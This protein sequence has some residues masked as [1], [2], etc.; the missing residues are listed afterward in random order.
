[1]G[2]PAK[3]FEYLGAQRPILALAEPESDVAWVL[4]ESGC[5]HRIV[6]PTDPARVK[7]ALTDLVNEKAEGRA[8]SPRSPPAAGFTRQAMAQR[9]AETLSRC[10]HPQDGTEE[11]LVG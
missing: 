11:G 4:K 10:V 8:V 5:V 6:A 2:I 1:M 7:Q 3:L 9:L